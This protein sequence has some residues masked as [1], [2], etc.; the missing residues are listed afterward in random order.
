MRKL[1]Y[2]FLIVVAF[3][4]GFVFNGLITRIPPGGR[5][6]SRLIV[7]KHDILRYYAMYKSVP[8]DLADVTLLAHHDGK[9][10]VPQNEWG[11][12]ILISITNDTVVTLRTLRSE[13]E[14]TDVKQ[15]FV[16]EFD[17]RGS[18]E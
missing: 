2:W 15:E 16:L 13:V 7:L 9:D 1:V 6:C 5:T 14:S 12:P 4:V 18:G 17:V 8:K 3:F 11:A 10:H